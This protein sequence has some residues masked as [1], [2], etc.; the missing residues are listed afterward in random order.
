MWLALLFR[1]LWLG[2]LFRALWLL[3]WFGILGI[4]GFLAFGAIHKVF[5]IFLSCFGLFVV[6]RFFLCGILTHLFC[7]VLEGVA[8][9]LFGLA[10]GGFTQGVFGTLWISA[11]GIFL[12]IWGVLGVLGVFPL[13]GVGVLCVL[14]VLGVFPLTGVGVLCV[15]CV[16]CVFPL[17]G[18]GVLCVLCVFP[19]TGV[20]VLCVLGLLLEVLG[21]FVERALE[22]VEGL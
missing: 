4:F 3:L 13:T 6:G 20:G 22:F 19:L 5:D 8:L 14:C 9:L 21:L 18:V 17:T 10:F 2:L 12:R 16:L 7:E 11:L 1:A 15:L